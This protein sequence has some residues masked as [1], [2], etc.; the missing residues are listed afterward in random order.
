MEPWFQVLK[1]VLKSDIV[2]Y[3]AVVDVVMLAYGC[4]RKGASS[5]RALEKWGH[6]INKIIQWHCF[7][8]SGN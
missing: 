6:S 8:C 2:A 4:M 5:V 1:T 7:V 3:A